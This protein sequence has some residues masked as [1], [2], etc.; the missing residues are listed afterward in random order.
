MKK[1]AQNL[2]RL[3]RNRGVTRASDPR[4]L[5][6]QGQK[7]TSVPQP[8]PILVPVSVLYLVVPV[9]GMLTLL[10]AGTYRR[11]MLL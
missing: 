9:S 4:P 11:P 6:K 5:L 1:T 7:V 10:L 8:W 3:Q 2:I